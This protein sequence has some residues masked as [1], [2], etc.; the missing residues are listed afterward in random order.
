MTDVPLIH[1]SKGNLPVS[2]L[3]YDPQW[4]DTSDY[5]K[6]IERYWLGDEIVKESAHV[7]TKRGLSSDAVAQP[8]A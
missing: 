8:L 7:L 5:T 1:T 2:S 6:F 4:V 3:R